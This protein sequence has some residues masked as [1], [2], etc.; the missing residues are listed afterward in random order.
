ME[1]NL[2]YQYELLEIDENSSIEDIKRSYRRLC[3]KYHPDKLN[4][5][6]HR[7]IEIKNAY[8]E[9]IK[10]KEQKINFFVMFYYFILRFNKNTDV[11][12]SLKINVQDIY[13]GSIKKVSYNRLMED[14]KRK[15]CV[16][17]LELAGYEEEYRIEDK[18][19]YNMLTGQYG[20]LVIKLD[21]SHEGFEGF[22]LNKLVNLYDIYVTMD[23]N[24]YEYYY[25]V[26]KLLNYFNDERIHLL[27]TP[28]L[29]GDT[30]M[31]PQKGLPNI[32]YE[33]GNLYVFYQVDLHRIN[34]KEHN[35]ESCIKNLFNK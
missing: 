18:G 32:N 13:N 24:L 1:K 12:L 35:T 5:D 6:S 29:S 31:I 15:S 22:K 16:L 4:G 23:I 2:C 20:G 14:M 3:L 30:Q 7:F 25:G 9:V 26:D 21:V 17:F 19:D 11:V 27:H 8:E 34:I 28:Y 33:Y 10:I